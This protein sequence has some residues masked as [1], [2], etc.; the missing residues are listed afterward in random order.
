MDSYSSCILT[1]TSKKTKKRKKK[2]ANDC[3]TSIKIWCDQSGVWPQALSAN[4]R[5]SNYLHPWT[6]V[7]SRNAFFF[8]F[9]HP[10]APNSSA[11]YR[12][13]RVDKSGLYGRV[14]PTVYLLVTFAA[15]PQPHHNY[16]TYSLNRNHAWQEP[17]ATKVA[18]LKA[19][20]CLRSSMAT[21]LWK[22]SIHLDISM[23]S[24]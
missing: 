6:W 13:S 5:F 14:A 21:A 3:W 12:G 17:L 16:P 10:S 22:D 4:N 11:G 15:R 9:K 18:V 7:K 24:L 23:G 1:M 2:L 20:F 19:I 8:F